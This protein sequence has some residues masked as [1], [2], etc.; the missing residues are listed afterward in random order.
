[1][2]EATLLNTPVVLLTAGLTGFV[3][4]SV[5]VYAAL[6]LLTVTVPVETVH[7]GCNTAAVGIAGVALNDPPAKSCKEAVID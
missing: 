4:V 2:P 3:P 6:K 7:E 5:Y 1:M